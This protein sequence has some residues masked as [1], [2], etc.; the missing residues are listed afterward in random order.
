LAYARKISSQFSIGGQIRYLYEY[1]GSNIIVTTDGDEVSVDNQI[2]TLSF[3]LGTRYHTDFKSLAFSMT[4]QNFS[5]DIKYHYESFSPPLIFKIGVS[6][7]LLDLINNPSRSQ[8]LLAVDALHPR[9]YS[10]R[11]NVGLEYDY[12]GMFKLRSGYRYNYDEGD[13]TFGG[14]LRYPLRSGLVLRCDISYLM[15]PADRFVSPM[16]ITA[17]VDF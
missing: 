12:L 4:I 2:G 14:G 1:Y 10:E 3:D 17:G 9:D 13:F 7:D 15:M 8:L 6:M 16:Q 11:I 5:P